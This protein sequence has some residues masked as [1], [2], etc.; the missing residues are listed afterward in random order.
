MRIM[1]NP[2]NV[3]KLDLDELLAIWERLSLQVKSL[4]E[5]HLSL[6]TA[7]SLCLLV[8][9]SLGYFF[10]RESR[11]SGVYAWSNGVATIKGASGPI[12]GPLLSFKWPGYSA[13]IAPWALKELERKNTTEL[14]ELMLSGVPLKMRAQAKLLLPSLLS[15]CERFGVDPFWAMAILWTESHFRLHVKSYAGAYGPMQ[16]MPATAHYILWKQ[17]VRVS[18]K[19]AARLRTIPGRNVDLGVY[20]LSEL[21]SEFDGNYKLATIAYNMGPFGLKKALAQGRS[22]GHNHRYWKRVVG[23]LKLLLD[24]AAPR[25][26]PWRQFNE[27]TLEEFAVKGFKLPLLGVVTK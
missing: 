22:I 21:L 26:G 15:A 18:S 5:E 10:S 8:A 11:L 13:P 23:H 25:L 14:E 4:Y 24:S 3:P 17:G 2:V 19:E 7:L 12:P 6:R 27:K 9:L 16:I 1:T 20:Y